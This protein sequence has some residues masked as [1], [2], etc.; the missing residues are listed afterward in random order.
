MPP[1]QENSA[2]EDEIL[3][4]LVAIF[5]SE[6]FARLRMSDLAKRLHCSTATLYR[7]GASKEDLLVHAIGRVMNQT[8]DDIVARTE[9][10]TS[11][12][13]QARYFSEQ[14]TNFIGSFS[15]AFLA[16]VGRYRAM[17]QAWESGRSRA[18]DHLAG[19]LEEAM[20]S[21]EVRQMN[22]RYLAFL[23][24]RVTDLHSDIETERELGLARPEAL[25]EFR[26]VIWQG[27]SLDGE[28]PSYSERG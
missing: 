14:V 18:I 21:G 2:R 4:G 7:I 19:Y 27:L 15:P 25:E 9:T 12:A 28:M 20:A 26:R 3:D 23:F 22:P 1:A 5:S 6:G 8:L 24:A 16:D 17:H 13:V 11:P 10:F